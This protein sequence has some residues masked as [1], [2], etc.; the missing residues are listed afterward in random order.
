MSY[1]LAFLEGIITFISP[2]LLPML[3]LYISYF[4][5]GNDNKHKT[6][7]K[8]IS[9]TVGFTMVFVLLG[10]LSSSFGAYL[11]EHTTIINIITGSIVILFGLNF[12]GVIKIGFLNR[13]KNIDYD[14]NNLS[15]FKSFIFGIVFSISWSPCVGVFLGS[16]L[17]LA[18]NSA[19]IIRGTLMLLLYSLGLAIPF[20]LSAVL[21][22]ELKST[23]E[24]IK[25]HYA[26][27]NKISGTILLVIGIFM[28][29]GNMSI[30]YW[31]GKW[32]KL[33]L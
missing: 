11:K 29:S 25:K 26:I 24:F 21:I 27:I 15:I 9:F 22:E 32:K 2:C 18:A 31:G 30:F 4:M 12:L 1:L 33:L 28:L 14:T 20:I 16:A 3:P 5:A 17:M 7:L 23:L 6:L 8:V 10:V 19:S 13:E